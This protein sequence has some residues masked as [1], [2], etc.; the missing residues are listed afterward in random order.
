MCFFTI[1]TGWKLCLI[2]NAQ[3]ITCTVPPYDYYRLI[4][5]KFQLNV[6]KLSKIRTSK[7]SCTLYSVDCMQFVVS[8]F[9][10]LM[11]LFKKCGVMIN[12]SSINKNFRYTHF[13]N[14]LFDPLQTAL[15]FTIMNFKERTYPDVAKIWICY[16]NRIWWLAAISH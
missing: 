4:F 15:V 7:V 12:H 3:C 11:H 10:L 9:V 1:L 8:M 6:K 5:L 14:N 13:K 16:I 2:W